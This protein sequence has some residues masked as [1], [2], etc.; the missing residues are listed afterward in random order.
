MTTAPQLRESVVATYA[1]HLVEKASDEVRVMA[2]RANPAWDGPQELDVEGRRVLVRG[3][4]SSLAVREA[5][6]DMVDGDFLV[7]LT[8]QD[9]DALGESLTSRFWHQ[10]VEMVD[11][12]RSV[13]DLFSAL[14]VASEVKALGSEFAQTLADARPVAG[15]P[16]ASTGVVTADVAMQ[17]LLA[18]VLQA[19]VVDLDSLLARSGDAETK[20]RW[21]QIPEQ[22]R[23]AVGV[24]ARDGLGLVAPVILDVLASPTRIDAVTVGLAADVI[25]VPGAPREADQAA[26]RLEEYFAGHGPNAD[27]GRA[28]ANACKDYLRRLPVEDPRRAQ[29]ASRAQQLLADVRWPQ[30]AQNS[31]ILPDGYAALARELAAQLLDESSTQVESAL[32]ALEGHDLAEAQFRSATQ[33]ARMAV[34]LRRWLVIDKPTPSTLG[35][36][37]ERQVRIDAWVDLALADV[38][39]G[40]MDPL[41]ADAYR[42][43][44]A[45]V[46][47]VRRE[48]DAQFASLLAAAGPGPL[49]VEDVL[50]KV[51]LPIAAVSSVLLIV[52]DGMSAAV[53]AELAEGI[54]RRGWSEMI[55]GTGRLPVLAA[56]PTVTRYSRTSLFAGRLTDGGQAD[57]K[58]AFG[59]PLFHKDDLRA[60]AGEELAPSVRAA[61]TSADRLV[62]VVLNTVDDALAKADPGGTD[63]TVESVQHLSALLD[64]ASAVGRTVI[65]TSDHG[66]V[67]ER[68]SQRVAVAG[69]DARYR[70]SG[71][72]GKGEVLLTGPRV[73]AHGGAV[74]AAVSEDLRYG[75]K[76]AGYHGGASA[77]EVTIPLLVFSQFPDDLAATSWRP[78]VPQAPD[79]WVASADVPVRRVTKKA[80][81]QAI[82]QESLFEEPTGSPGSLLADQLAASA[83]FIERMQRVQ[84]QLSATAVVEAVRCL[85]DASGRAHKDLVARAAGLPA[86]RIAGAFPI[87]QRVLNVEGYQVLSMDVDGV[88]MVLDRALLTEQFGLGS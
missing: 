61:I 79:W 39:S 65:L 15:Y 36:A 6:M 57:E 18:A 46:Q 4:P 81:V 16:V 34:R 27:L 58:A 1:R 8:D 40:S 54:E 69:A 2:L 41:V 71:D 24:W 42:H 70:P 49:G 80:P 44:V 59:G 31:L 77:A 25:Y 87:M 63:W 11:P 47:A 60:P 29:I 43:V 38:F 56:L 14:S 88:T 62:G 35:E 76:S 13:A 55:T 10:R 20:A 3:C 23:Q 50:A 66:H 51:V 17:G 12:W 85:V 22:V 75:N 21:Q 37:L 52:V 67:V 53:A 84:R 48:H 64:L 83:L 74:V 26:V 9:A 78:A 5:F 28:F 82:G 30:G 19:D 68:G 7:V 33:R 32:K 73:L 72:A 45:R 86:V